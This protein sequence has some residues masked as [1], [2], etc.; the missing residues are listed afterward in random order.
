MMHSTFHITDE[1]MKAMLDHCFS[2]AVTQPDKDAARHLRNTLVG[3]HN[4]YDTVLFDVLQMTARGDKKA[5][6]EMAFLIGM[7]AGY[8]LGISHLPRT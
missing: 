8:E 3:T 4:S 7:Q 5:V 2:S 6:A 1:M